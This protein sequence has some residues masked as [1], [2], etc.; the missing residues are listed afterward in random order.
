VL[1]GRL[2]AVLEVGGVRTLRRQ[3]HRFRT[4]QG[5]GR[6][7]LAEIDPFRVLWARPSDIEYVQ[8]RGTVGKA[9]RSICYVIDGD[10][11][12][13]EQ[14]FADHYIYQALRQRFVEG[15]AWSDI[16]FL[17]QVRRRIRERGEYWNGC[18]SEDDIRARCAFVDRLFA[19]I[20]E[21]GYAAP[22]GIEPGI[23]GLSLDDVP[24]AV[25]ISVGRS[26]RMFYAAG[27]HRLSIVKILGLPSLP[28]RVVARHSAWQA[29]RDD[30]FASGRES[31][32]RRLSEYSDHPD[33]AYL[34]TTES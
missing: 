20:Q 33:I 18:R 21:K 31:Q 32:A 4:W 9:D 2:K 13:Y 15:K 11:D 12:L 14:K 27:R 23:S 3:H 6:F 17:E 16:L 7:H 10:W 22:A 8:M 25:A 26:G 5:C 19:E 24:C 29:L 1:G 28:V 34:R 30:F